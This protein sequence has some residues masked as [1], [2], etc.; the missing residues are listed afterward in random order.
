MSAAVYDAVVW[1]LAFALCVPG[2]DTRPG[3]GVAALL[4]AA[5]LLHLPVAG[6]T[7][8]AVLRG[9]F[10]TPAV[11]TL[12]VLA[13][14]FAA[15]C[16]Q[17]PLFARGEALLMA[18]VAAAVGILIYPLALGLGPLDPYAW[19]YGG[20]GL[21]LGTGALT[22][23]CGLAG[24]WVLAA[25]LALGLVMWRLQALESPN[26]WDYLIDPLFSLGGL[27]ALLATA[28]AGAR[29]RRTLRSVQA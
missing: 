20:A 8:L 7:A 10:A 19:G 22:L 5:L 13:V 9:M 28:L 3:R 1:A 11:T 27:I 24:R 21:A 16:A 6:T 14:L 17:R 23:L 4:G 18:G 25:A 15:R 2:L 26:L 12:I 29:A